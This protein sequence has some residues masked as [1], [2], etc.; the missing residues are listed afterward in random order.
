VPTAGGR[1][2]SDAEGGWEPVAPSA[3]EFDEGYRTPRALTADEIRALPG[4]FAAAARRAA[5]VGFRVVELHMAHGYLLHQFLSPLS[6]RRV[7]EWGGSLANRL[8]LPVEVARAVRSKWPEGLALFARISCTDW[9][10]GGF[11]PEEAV[12]LARA[13]SGA[14]VDLVDC[15]TG[16]TLPAARIPVGPGFQVPFAERIRRE[17]GVRTAAVGLITE[18]AQADAVVRE[19]KA[20]LVLLGRQLLREPYFPLRAAAAL[21]AA[22]PWPPQYLRA[23]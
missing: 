1:P 6:N 22:A 10:E 9:A 12:E 16:G 3:V 2:L 19:E 23:R 7:D 13:L 8:R 18:P 5:R 20:D 11:T 4:A 21:G 17:A 15:S 14:G